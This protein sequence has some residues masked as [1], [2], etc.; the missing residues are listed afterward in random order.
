MKSKFTKQNDPFIF[1][2]FFFTN[3][4]SLPSHLREIIDFITIS[5]LLNLGGDTGKRG[6]ITRVYKN[7]RWSREE[8]GGKEFWMWWTGVGAR[9]TSLPVSSRR[10][11]VAKFG[12]LSENQPYVCSPRSQDTPSNGSRLLSNSPTW[13][14][15][16]DPRAQCLASLSRSPRSHRA[17]AS[18]AHPI[19]RIQ[20][21]SDFQRDSR[22]Q[23]EPGLETSLPFRPGKFSFFSSLFLLF[24]TNRASTHISATRS[25]NQH[26]L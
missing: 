1:F 24:Y 6:E 21:V 12:R 23:C 25:S 3:I 9:Q 13:M 2:F 15:T 20:I 5:K 26:R 17:R 10:D 16:R 22:A 18:R 8:M 19:T 11:T 4:L 7:K 14:Q